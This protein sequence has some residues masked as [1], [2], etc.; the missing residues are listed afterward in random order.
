MLSGFGLKPPSLLVPFGLSN[1][2]RVGEW[3]PVRRPPRREGAPFTRSTGFLHDTDIASFFFFF[4]F[5]GGGG[6]V[7]VRNAT[8]V[9]TY[10]YAYSWHECHC[11]R[12]V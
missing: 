5:L 6:V 1:F 12:H 10:T 8:H 4:F 11:C 2:Y 9:H 3:G 7:V